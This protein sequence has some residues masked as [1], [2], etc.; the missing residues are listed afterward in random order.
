MCLEMMPSWCWQVNWGN[1]GIPWLNWAVLCERRLEMTVLRPAPLP[2]KTAPFTQFFLQVWRQTVK[3]LSLT[4]SVKGALKTT[5]RRRRVCS[6]DGLTLTG[7]KQQYSD[8]IL[9]QS[10]SFYH[11]FH[12][13]SPRIEPGPSHKR[14]VTKRRCFIKA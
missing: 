1:C 4:N 5:C 13:N 3:S 6:L 2:V 14:P 10:H 12:V 9:S 7:Q 11:K 8:K